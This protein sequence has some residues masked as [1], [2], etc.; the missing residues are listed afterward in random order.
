[1]EAIIKPNENAPELFKS[2]FL[3]KLT[4]SHPALIFSLYALISAVL[5]YVGTIHF[6][7]HTNTV[8]ILSLTGLFSWTL[9]EYLMHRFLYHEIS[10]AGYDKGVR[11]I[12]H[13]IHHRYPNDAS[14]VVLPPLPSL[15]IAAVFFLVFY[16]LMG[17]Y[18]LA[19]GPGFMMGYSVYMWVHY[20]VH[21]YPSPKRFN[22][23]W[24]HH[25]IH[26]FQQH[27][28]AFGVSTPIWDYV[29]GTMPEPNRK[30]IKIVLKK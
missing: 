17:R 21:K 22:F 6:E 30:T 12:F 14:K 15:L 27:D 24:K 9:G 1:M 18:A 29:F 13:G 26:H 7:L 28:R 2:K 4:W 8:M 5:I 19:F 11:Y 20:A 23:W 25:N 3:N 16:V 10:N